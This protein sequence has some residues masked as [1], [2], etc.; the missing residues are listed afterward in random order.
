MKIRRH[1][2]DYNFM[3]DTLSGVT[4]RWGSVFTENP[5]LAPWPELV[6]ISISSHCSKG[7]SYC[8]RDCRPNH[9]FITIEDYEFILRSLIHPQWGTVFQAAIGGG[10]PLEHPH[11]ENIV[12]KTLEYGIIP[13]LTTNGK[14]ITKDIAAFLENR[15][16]AVALSVSNPEDIIYQTHRILINQGVRTNI[17]YVL[18][19][20]SIEGAIGILEGRYNKI[21]SGVNGVIFLTY[22]ATGRA[23]KDNCL[24]WNDSLKSFIRLI[25]NN[26]CS[27]KIG[28]D[29]CF[30]LSFSI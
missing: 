27:A 11:F 26:N 9:S 10:E 29:A 6:D 16:G 25:D 14:L 24:K 18:S 21:L 19:K 28:F 22:K 7:C 17:H 12:N 15:A 23:K 4:F 13:N 1:S 2:R 3:G 8:Y 5:R 30:A 20:D